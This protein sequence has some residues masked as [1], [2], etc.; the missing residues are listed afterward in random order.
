M[1]DIGGFKRIFNWF[2]VR[3]IYCYRYC[4]AGEECR[5]YEWTWVYFSDIFTTTI[6]DLPWVCRIVLQLWW[7][8]YRGSYSIGFCQLLWVL[9]V[10]CVRVFDSTTSVIVCPVQLYAVG[11]WKR[12]LSIFHHPLIA[13][14]L[15]LPAIK[16]H[17]TV[18][19]ISARSLDTM[20][21]QGNIRSVLESRISQESLQHSSYINDYR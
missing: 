10:G 5:H 12:P 1:D 21:S 15:I 6:A 2:E 18:P 7:S 13:L 4:R 8:Y 14:K 3:D 9:V 11:F 17:N 19:L 20:K 16:P